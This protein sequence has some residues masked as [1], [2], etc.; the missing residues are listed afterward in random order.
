MAWLPHGFKIKP[1]TYDLLIAPA[2]SVL[3]LG[4]ILI[5]NNYK[6]IQNPVLIMIVI[7]ILVTYLTNNTRFGRYIY[8]VG[9]N[10]EAARL[11]GINVQSIVFKVFILMGLLSGVAGIVLND[12]VA[13]G[14]IGSGTNY[15]LSAIGGCVIGG[16]SLMEVKEQFLEL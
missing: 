6:G 9:G 8:A 10:R 7:A 4:F 15:E 16:A 11:S 12:Y 14:A 5:V 2:Y 3:V 1:F 13:A